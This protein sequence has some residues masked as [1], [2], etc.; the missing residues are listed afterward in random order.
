MAI[1][2]PF[3]TPQHLGSLLAGA[4]MANGHDGR[5]PRARRRTPRYNCSKIEVP[6]AGSGDPAL[7]M[8]FDGGAAGKNQSFSLVWRLMS[9][10]VAA[11]TMSTAPTM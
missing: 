7:R 5:S 11:A 1:R 6:A 9:S 4:V 8:V 3:S 2:F 10:S